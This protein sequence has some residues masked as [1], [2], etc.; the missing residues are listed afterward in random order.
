MSFSKGEN[1]MYAA[2]QNKIFENIAVNY[3]D[4]YKKHSIQK[5][6]MQ[7]SILSVECGQWC[8]DCLKIFLDL[9]KLESNDSLSVEDKKKTISYFRE[10]VC[11]GA[12]VCNVNKLAMTNDVVFIT[13]NTIVDDVD[14]DLITEKLNSFLSEQY[15]N[16]NFKEA[17]SKDK[18]SQIVND[19]NINL[20][21]NISQSVATFQTVKIEGAGN[22]KNVSVDVM[23][24]AVM[25]S[26]VNNKQTVE[27]LTS[28]AQAIF[29]KITQDVKKSFSDELKAM[30]TK[31]KTQLIVMLVMF[32]IAF[33]L[34]IILI[35]YQTYAIVK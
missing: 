16:E 22:I 4:V 34:Q 6:Q 32:A 26:M 23:V 5:I 30:Y 12:C 25:V 31:Y 20:S 3:V 1:L 33:F 17:A 2:I 13:E 10:G 19:I 24:R 28:I 9:D 11:K 14:V 8:E 18:I 15:K 29:S 7:T 27:S 35:I 21:T